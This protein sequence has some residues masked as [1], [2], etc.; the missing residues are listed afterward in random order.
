[1]ELDEH[2]EQLASKRSS[3][4]RPPPSTVKPPGFLYSIGATVRWTSIDTVDETTYGAVVG[5]D[6]PNMVN[7]TYLYKHLYIM[8]QV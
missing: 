6:E 7:K 2:D 1:M 4:A 3:T 8:E 5:Y